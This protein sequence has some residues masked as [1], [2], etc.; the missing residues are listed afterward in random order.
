MYAILNGSNYITMWLV[1]YVGAPNVTKTVVNRT[2]YWLY[3][4]LSH[5]A[6][7]SSKTRGTK[8]HPMPSLCVLIENPFKISPGYVRLHKISNDKIDCLIRSHFMFNPIETCFAKYLHKNMAF[9][10]KHSGCNIGMMI[11]RTK[12][13]LRVHSTTMPIMTPVKLSHSESSKIKKNDLP[14]IF[15]LYTCPGCPES[16]MNII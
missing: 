12:S 7:W 11:W 1:A 8:A 13:T 2:M 9:E 4:L 6:A 3:A 10:C 16:S 15:A 14:T 5:T